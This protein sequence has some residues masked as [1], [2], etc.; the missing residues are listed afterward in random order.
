MFT[1][2]EDAAAAASKELVVLREA[3]D[4]NRTA[5]SQTQ[6]EIQLLRAKQ[7][8]ERAAS[9]AFLEELR[10]EMADTLR[11]LDRLQRVQSGPTVPEAELVR[12]RELLEAKRNELLIAKREVTLLEGVLRIHADTPGLKLREQMRALY[13][14]IEVVALGNSA[15]PPSNHQQQNRFNNNNN[16][17]QNLGNGGDFS[18]Y[19]NQLPAHLVN[20]NLPRLS[21]AHP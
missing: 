21:M 3:I 14:E 19:N 20:S 10:G 8:S 15:P 17:N 13:P 2:A 12:A 16:P 6:H 9:E 4:R 11:A 5:I 18:N 1:S 7:E